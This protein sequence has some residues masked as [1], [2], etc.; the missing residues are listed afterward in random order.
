MPEIEV[1]PHYEDVTSQA[2]E[3]RGMK[4]LHVGIQQRSTRDLQ[5]CVKA[6]LLNSVDPELLER[7]R[8]EAND[9]PSPALPSDGNGR[10]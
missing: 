2:E 8:R 5:K 6:D 3:P 7:L 1:T 9:E 10:R 4:L